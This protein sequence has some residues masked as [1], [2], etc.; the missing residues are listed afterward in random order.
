MKIKKIEVAGYAGARSVN[1]RP[2]TQVILFAGTN[3]AG[4]SSVAEGV[5]HALAG[6]ASRV[7]LKK[8]F[9]ANLMT[10]GEKSGS[11]LVGTDLGE[12]CVSLPSG[13]GIHHDHPAL[14]FVLSPEMFAEQTPDNRRAFLFAL[15][16]LSVSPQA[17]GDELKARGASAE[18]VKALSFALGS[19]EAGAKEA[20]GQARDA[21]TRWKVCTGETW[22]KDK[23]AA[24][25]ASLPAAFSDEDLR[26]AHDRVLNI[27][28]Q[29]EA[30]NQ[31][32][33][34]ARAAVQQRIDLERR[35]EG[36]A[37]SAG[38]LD[39]MRKKLE[40]DLGQLEENRKLLAD[41]PPPQGAKPRTHPCPCCGAVLEH[42]MA[43][44][45][46]V[47]HVPGAPIDPDLEPRRQL[48]TNAVNLYERSV[49]N[50]HRD[51]ATAEAAARSLEDA[52]AQLEGMPA[53]DKREGLENLLATYRAEEKEAQKH[54]ESMRAANKAVAD[55][56]A[57]TAQAAQAN[58]DAVEWLE[59]A[60]ALAPGGIQAEILGRALSPINADLARFSDEAQWPAVTIDA[61]MEIRAGG[62]IYSLLSKSEKWRVNAVIGAAIAVRSGLRILMLDEFDI[63]NTSGREDL[64]FW[65]DALAQAGELDTV[66]IFGT[67]KAAPAL[68]MDYVSSLWI[69]RGM[70]GEPKLQEAA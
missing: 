5:R 49:A 18:K 21:K 29:I 52:K 34:M 60:D 58:A 12:F 44:G 53:S 41:L 61:D 15:F 23:A 50:D 70:C 24:W 25:K 2:A 8:D 17:I 46:L 19:F 10:E 54:L 51:I 56:E 45:A 47:E 63:L 39:S 11:V 59:I 68:G 57:V 27:G 69:E 1:V 64:L 37:A 32:I 33:G 20:Q 16:G 42:R 14:P 38:R 4:K 36:L 31:S 55:A 48:L 35:I 9:K 43:D 62:R 26:A 66:L 3:G 6:D 28:A 65:V 30:T 7:K 22:G 67:L 13:K 40:H